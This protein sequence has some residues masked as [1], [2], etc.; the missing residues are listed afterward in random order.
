MIKATG[1][2]GLHGTPVINGLFL[3]PALVFASPDS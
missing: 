2:R 1:K 3:V